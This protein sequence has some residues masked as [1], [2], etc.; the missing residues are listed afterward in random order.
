VA[1]LTGQKDLA[2]DDLK[3]DDLRFWA[4]EH[5]V[6]VYGLKLKADPSIASL[7]MCNRPVL[8]DNR[9]LLTRV[10]VGKGRLYLCQLLLPDN[11]ADEPAARLILAGLLT[12]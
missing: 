1:H 12:D 4:K 8:D 7:V 6:A 10:T 5:A 9:S 3:N 11:A 2:I